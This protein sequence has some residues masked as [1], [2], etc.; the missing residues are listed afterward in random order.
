MAPRNGHLPSVGFLRE[1]RQIEDL[2]LHTVIVDDKDY[3]PLLELH[4]LKR[5]R[6]MEVRGMAPTMESLRAALPWDG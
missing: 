1:L 4:R 3:S 6:V 2:L 5:V